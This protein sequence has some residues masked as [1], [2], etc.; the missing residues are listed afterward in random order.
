MHAWYGG[1]PEGR[2][3]RSGR[4]GMGC[5]WQGLPADIEPSGMARVWTLRVVARDS[6]NVSAPCSSR[7]SS[8]AVSMS[9]CTLQAAGI[10]RLAPAPG[11]PDPTS[12]RAIVSS[13]DGSSCHIVAL[14]HLLQCTSSVLW[15]AP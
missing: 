3:T 13:S 7:W 11:S 6:E 5:G 2:N 14:L 15:G 10:V 9:S 1:M 12:M 8:T 4:T